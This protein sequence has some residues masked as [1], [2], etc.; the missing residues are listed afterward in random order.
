[1]LGR[2]F[3]GLLCLNG[4]ALVGGLALGIDKAAE[5]FLLL[6][7]R[8]GV[9]CDGLSGPVQLLYGV[10]ELS[11]T[12]GTSCGELGRLDEPFSQP[13]FLESS[14]SDGLQLAS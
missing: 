6:F 12:E 3:Q 5:R 11:V 9:A 7:E 2:P 10:L 14:V 4:G 1:M 13:G 8:F